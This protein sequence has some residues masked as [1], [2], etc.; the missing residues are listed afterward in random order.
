MNSKI[1]SGKYNEGGWIE[2]E[3]CSVAGCSPS[4]RSRGQSILINSGLVDT[5]IRWSLFF[6]GTE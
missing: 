1:G 5:S 6:T 4:S 2:D 3:M